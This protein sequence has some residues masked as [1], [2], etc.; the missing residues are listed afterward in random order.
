MDAVVTTPTEGSGKSI[1]AEQ[2]NKGGQIVYRQR[3]QASYP[4]KIVTSFTRPND[5]TAYATGEAVTNSTTV[6]VALTFA[7]A[8]RFAGGGGR[9]TGAQLLDSANVATKGKFELWLFA[10]AAAP[11]P[12]NDNAV[13]T[14]TDAELADLVAVIQLLDTNAFVGDATAGAGG[15]ATYVG[16]H[17]TVPNFGIPFRCNAA[18][19]SLFGLLVVRNAYVPVALEV[20]TL[21]LLIDQE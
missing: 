1:D 17:L 16:T 12:D 2:E 15:N 20:F 4:A 21:S 10:G 11:A 14:P 8:A 7:G 18:V 19:T 13:F 9:I 3:V 5:T 6:P